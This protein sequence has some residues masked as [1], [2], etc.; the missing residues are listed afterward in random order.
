MPQTPTAMFMGLICSL[1]PHTICLRCLIY[2]ASTIIGLNI[3]LFVLWSMLLIELYACKI[4]GY[5]QG[6]LNN[7][8]QCCVPWNNSGWKCSNN[9]GIVPYYCCKHDVFFI[10]NIKDLYILHFLLPLWC[11]FPDSKCAFLPFVSQDYE[12]PLTYHS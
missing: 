12:H 4:L 11:L 5:V 6:Y 9:D 7:S 8:S 1:C 10:I 2:T 3:Y